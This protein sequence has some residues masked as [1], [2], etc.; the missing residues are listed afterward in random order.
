MTQPRL[1]FFLDE[2][3]ATEM[4]KPKINDCFGIKKNLYSLHVD[5]NSI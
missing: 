3:A 2:K 1:D 5:I 4:F